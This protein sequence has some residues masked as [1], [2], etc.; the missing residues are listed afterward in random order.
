MKEIN[1]ILRKRNGMDKSDPSDSSASK[2]GQV[3]RLGHRLGLYQRHQ[4][5][6][7]AEL[8]AGNESFSSAP[9]C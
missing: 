5:Q 3:V 4:A 2:S 6:A 9:G 8:K 1:D 7:L